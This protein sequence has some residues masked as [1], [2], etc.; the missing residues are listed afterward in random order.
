[1][2]LSHCFFKST[3]CRKSPPSAMCVHITLLQHPSP[4]L[5]WVSVRGLYPNPC[6]GQRVSISWL[7]SKCCTALVVCRACTPACTGL[8]ICE[9]FIIIKL[10]PHLTRR[11]ILLT[12]CI[13]HPRLHL[14]VLLYDNLHHHLI[15]RW[16]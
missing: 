11:V 7:L 6:S 16:R 4:V 5:V 2:K 14:N 12:K 13:L 1:M 3:N 9:G 15:I 8:G 10:L